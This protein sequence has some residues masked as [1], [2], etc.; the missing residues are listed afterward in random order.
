ML[1]NIVFPHILDPDS[2]TALKVHINILY[3]GIM[4]N[5]T[6]SKYGH[7]RINM[8]VYIK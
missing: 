5:T 1:W 4:Q 8:Q 6:D 7:R 3:E 2:Q